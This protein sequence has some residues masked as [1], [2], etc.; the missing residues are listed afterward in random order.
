MFAHSVCVYVIAVPPL[1]VASISIKTVVNKGNKHEIVAISVLTHDQI[2]IEGDT[3][4]PEA[5]VRIRSCLSS[6]VVFH[7]AILFLHWLLVAGAPFG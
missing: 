5:K 3:L 1:R 7:A 4:R 6:Y 2:S